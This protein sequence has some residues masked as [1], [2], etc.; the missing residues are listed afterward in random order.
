MRPEDIY[1]SIDPETWTQAFREAIHVDV[2][3]AILQ[4]WF[5]Q[6]IRS[7]AAFGRNQA[8]RQAAQSCQMT[9]STWSDLL[10]AARQANTTAPD[11]LD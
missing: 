4:E 3:D 5:A 2:D 8:A 9:E 7:G 11:K 1:P 6:A 10:P